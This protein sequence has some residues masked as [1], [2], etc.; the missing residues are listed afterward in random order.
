M[1]SWEELQG[2]VLEDQERSWD[3]K[4]DKD[5]TWR[6]CHKS[7]R[8]AMFPGAWVCHRGV[9]L[10]VILKVQLQR[11]GEDYR[12]TQKNGKWLSLEE[13]PGRERTF[14]VYRPIILCIGKRGSWVPLTEG[15]TRGRMLLHQRWNCTCYKEGLPDMDTQSYN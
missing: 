12:K 14:T 15:Q 6:M 5:R 4:G 11:H 2:S 9:P 7:Q 13:I 1:V 3:A 8:S 10:G